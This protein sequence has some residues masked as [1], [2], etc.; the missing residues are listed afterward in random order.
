M[1]LTTTLAGFL[2]VLKR[3]ILYFAYAILSLILTF[4]IYLSAL[5][6]NVD[7]LHK[8]GL[9]RIEQISE[10]LLGRIASYQQLPN[11][12][13]NRE[14]VIE[15]LSG[16]RT[17]SEINQ[18]LLQSA[19]LTGA[20]D[21]YVLDK[22]G[23]VISSSNIENE[24]KRVGENFANEPHVKAAMEGSLG[25]YHSLSPDD[26]SRSFFFA[27]G[28]ITDQ[29][30]PMGA[31]VVEVK[32]DRLEFGWSF[33]EEAIAF[34]DENDVI[35]VTNRPE[36]NLRVV[37]VEPGKVGGSSFREYDGTYLRPFYP[38]TQSN[39]FDYTIMD[40]QEGID[41]PQKAL[42]IYREIPQISLTAKGFFDLGDAYLTAQ[43]QALL[44]AAVFAFFGVVFWALWQ[45][46]QRLTDRLAV[47]A[48]ANEQLE[49][50]V[51][52][53]TQQLRDTQDQLIQAGK[54][55]ALGQMSAGV[56]HEVNQPLSAIQNFANTGQKFIKRGRVD[57]AEKNFDLIADQTQRISRIIK[58]LRRFARNEVEDFEQVNLTDVI[59]ESVYLATMRSRR[60]AVEIITNIEEKQAFVMGGKVRL[61]QVLVNLITN[62][63]DALSVQ[64]DKR[65]EIDLT[66][67]GEHHKLAVKD[68]GS[69][70]D[71]PS[72]VFEPFYTTK[73]VGASNGLGLGLAISYGI[74]GSFNGD[75]TCKNRANG[76][77]E[78]TITLPKAEKVVS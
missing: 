19:L 38:F 76:G 29:T 17:I 2:N 52:E 30:Q 44:S 3:N 35:F 42:V 12:I 72:R 56:A 41:L 65:I 62:S 31:V 71:D 55:T 36:L 23:V 32:V 63:M 33:D 24:F 10:R 48:E 77:A 18:I 73:D 21:I 26:G 57:D 78:F 39:L 14:P 4:T 47:E 75:I 11:L 43:L 51:Q 67:N 13:A 34:L 20:S 69:G 25:F 70:L 58:N 68:N 28:I 54:L 9:V 15:L 64:S 50:R 61:E 1:N 22:N 46:R 66:S 8:S 5:Q 60:E 27:R 49:L 40:F 74:I 7:Q 45:R 6:I 59:R 16:K 37:G 53:R